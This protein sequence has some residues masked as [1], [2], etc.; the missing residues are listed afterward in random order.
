MSKKRI[1]TYWYSDEIS[2]GCWGKVLHYLTID[3]LQNINHQN[4]Y[5]DFITIVL[6]RIGFAG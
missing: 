1:I 4:K 2:E 6:T 5:N 3:M